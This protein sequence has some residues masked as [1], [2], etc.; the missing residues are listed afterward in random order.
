M[1]QFQ[2]RGMAL[3]L[4]LWVLSL[5]SLMA[6]S[7]ATT[8]RRDSAVTLVLKNRAQLMADAEAGF[9][10]AR[11]HMLQ[12]TLQQRQQWQRAIYR[13]QGQ[14]GEIRIKLAAEAGKVD[15]NAADPAL[16]AAVIKAA[17]AD[18]AGFQALVDALIDWRDADSQPLPQGA[19]APQYLALGAAVQP[20]NQPFTQ[21][22][23]LL[24]VRGFDATMLAR[25]KPWITVYSGRPQPELA[26]APLELLQLMAADF[27]RR[28]ISDS[29]VQQ[30]LA[31]RQSRFTATA[32]PLGSEPSAGENPSYTIMVEV[33]AADGMAHASVSAVV[34]LPSNALTD[35]QLPV[36]DWNTQALSPSLFADN[37]EP[38]LTLDDGFTFQH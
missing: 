36:L 15:I 16:I 3:L 34:T 4:V 31:A 23:D 13:L 37:S 11:Y 8:V 17:V 32:P 2:T 30:Q 19:E 33:L 10:V 25:L 29:A 27:K 21:L 1:N 18:D 26:D 22:D 20:S 28:R 14:A 5:L 38:L 24:Q 35:Q 9:A 12:A 7:F 6:A